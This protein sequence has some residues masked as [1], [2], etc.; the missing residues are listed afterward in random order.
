MFTL[1]KIIV[2]TIVELEIII[3]GR[4][5]TVHFP[6]KTKTTSIHDVAEMV[7]RNL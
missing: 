7:L 5:K 4:E 1:A 2:K 6:L 3:G